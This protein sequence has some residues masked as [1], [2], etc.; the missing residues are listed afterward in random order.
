MKRMMIFFLALMLMLPALSFADQDVLVSSGN[1]Q[2]DNIQVLGRNCY[3]TKDGDDER[4]WVFYEMYNGGANPININCGNSG[5]DFLDAKG[6]VIYATHDYLLSYPDIVAPG[7][8]FYIIE[9]LIR[10]YNPEAFPAA[11]QAA[12]YRLRLDLSSSYNVN[13]LYKFTAVNL[14]ITWTYEKKQ[15]GF[16]D[17]LFGS[18]GDHYYEFT[19]DITNN[20]GIDITNPGRSQ[21]GNIEIVI[22]L[23][24]QNGA[25][26][27]ISHESGG[28][29]DPGITELKAGQTK[30]AKISQNWNMVFDF[31]AQYDFTVTSA[32]LVAYITNSHL[33]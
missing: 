2:Y 29:A 9:D 6:N 13:D 22:I 15:S 16:F 3:T 14:P 24:D 27:F 20:T 30:H 32:E 23:R 12:D 28:F 8:K 4:I 26:I 31:F 17:K 21:M 33:Y 7:Q 25:P 10:E 11:T 19:F 18:K 1:Q 5:I